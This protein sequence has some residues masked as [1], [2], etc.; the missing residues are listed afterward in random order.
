MALAEGAGLFPVAGVHFHK[1]NPRQ[2]LTS[3]S[4]LTKA[5]GAAQPGPACA[6]VVRDSLSFQAR[7]SGWA[8]T[9]KG[10]GALG[11]FYGRLNACG[12]KHASS[13]PQQEQGEAGEGC[14]PWLMPTCAWL[15][16]ALLRL[17]CSTQPSPSPPSLHLSACRCT[18]HVGGV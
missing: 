10:A 7:H 6:G 9:F 15:S 16:A 18:A 12:I 17:R 1:S 4:P 13:L 8:R 2:L 5:Q 14:Q 11:S 3:A